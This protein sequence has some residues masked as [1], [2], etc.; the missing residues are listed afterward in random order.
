[1]SVHLWGIAFSEL[2]EG[3]RS[4]QKCQST[5]PVM[6]IRSALTDLLFGEPVRE[7]TQPRD[8]K[9]S[10]MCLHQQCTASGCIP[11]TSQASRDNKGNNSQ[12]PFQLLSCLPLATAQANEM[13]KSQ[14]RLC[15]FRT[16]TH[17]PRPTNYH[18]PTF[19]TLPLF[20]VL[21]ALMLSLWNRPSNKAIHSQASF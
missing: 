21:L 10:C 9:S 2:L 14:E 19:E 15:P 6:V 12:G 4:E 1:M 13:S 5:V 17:T 8:W 11:A 16:H 3:Q 18:L 7:E 20:M